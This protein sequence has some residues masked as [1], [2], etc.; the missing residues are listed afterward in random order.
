MLPPLLQIPL[1][2]LLPPESYKPKS[3]KEG[4]TVKGVV[5][6][7][8]VGEKGKDDRKGVPQAARKGGDRAALKKNLGDR[9]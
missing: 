6:G 8:L 4:G 2:F 5:L 7:S 3:G 9:A 1:V